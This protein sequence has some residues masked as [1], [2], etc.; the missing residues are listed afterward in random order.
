MLVTRPSW[1]LVSTGPGVSNPVNTAFLMQW[2][3]LIKL[4]L[5]CC[6]ETEKCVS[7]F[8]PLLPPGPVR[9]YYY[10]PYSLMW[11]IKF[12]LMRRG[13]PNHHSQQQEPAAAD[14]G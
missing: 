14:R 2:S 12:N 9:V 1:S 5:S 4:L 3:D 11:L 7:T 8:G 6:C 13:K 10:F